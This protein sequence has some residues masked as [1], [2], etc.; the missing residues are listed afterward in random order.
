MLREFD[1]MLCRELGNF[2]VLIKFVMNLLE[3]FHMGNYP[4]ARFRPLWRFRKLVRR[5][6]HYDRFSIDEWCV[7][8]N[9]NKQVACPKC[10]GRVPGEE[11]P[12]H[13]DHMCDMCTFI[14]S[15]KLEIFLAVK[16]FFVYQ[17]R[18]QRTT[19]TLLESEL[20][21]IEHA[22]LVE[23]ACDDARSVLS[24][25]CASPRVRHFDVRRSAAEMIRHLELLHDWY[26]L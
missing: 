7:S 1:V 10:D 24:R 4:G 12:V 23:M 18:C 25:P 3:C 8:C 19:E 2:P 6:H 16:E 13:A 17:I 15:V 5:T 11:D 20:G 26:G 9:K 14:R 21:W 22:R